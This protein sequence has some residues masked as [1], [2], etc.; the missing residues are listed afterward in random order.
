MLFLKYANFTL[1]G[2]VQINPYNVQGFFLM[3]IWA[4]VLIVIILLYHDAGLGNSTDI[5]KSKGW[6]PI[7]LIQNDYYNNYE[8]DID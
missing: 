7:T 6:A 8:S 1:P 3:C 5:P 2:G 4:S